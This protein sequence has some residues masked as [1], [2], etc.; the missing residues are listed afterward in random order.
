M[1]KEDNDDYLFENWLSQESYYVLI[2]TDFNMEVDSYE[3]WE[4]RYQ[5]KRDDFEDPVRK[6]LESSDYLQLFFMTADDLRVGFTLKMVQYLKDQCPK[7]EIIY[8]DVQTNAKSGPICFIPN[9]AE[10]SS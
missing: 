3:F 10:V 2:Q 6:K 5:Q 7:K 8:N 9:I 1:E 4:E